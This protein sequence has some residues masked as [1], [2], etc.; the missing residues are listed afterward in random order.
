MQG[1][2]ALGQ[3]E[4]LVS[5]PDS[6]AASLVSPDFSKVFSF[7]FWESVVAICLVG[8][9]ESLLHHGRVL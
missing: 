9:L 8:S 4:A 3:G 2:D 1:P 5:I 7:A 6:L